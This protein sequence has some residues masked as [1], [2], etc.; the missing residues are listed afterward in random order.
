MANQIGTFFAHEGDAKAAA[1]IANHLVK[2]W[3]PRMRAAIVE[4]LAAGGAGLDPIV[5]Q[6]VRTLKSDRT[7]P[8]A[9]R[10]GRRFR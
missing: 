8:Q 10:P 5:A 3:D 4:H 1:S 9:N 7:H 2:F 6:A